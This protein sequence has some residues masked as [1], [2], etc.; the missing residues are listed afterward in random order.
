M[1][2]SKPNNQSSVFIPNRS[3]IQ[4][5]EEEKNKTPQQSSIS[6]FGADMDTGRMTKYAGDA[7]GNLVSQEVMPSSEQVFQQYGN[8]IQQGNQRRQKEAVEAQRKKMLSDA[9]LGSA[10][11][12]TKQNKGFMP[13]DVTE[14]LSAQLGMPIVGGN[15]TQNGDFVIYGRKQLQSPN[16]MVS[17]ERIEPIAVASPEMQYGLLKR[18]GLGQSMQQEIF[19]KLSTRFTEQQLKDRG[20][21]NPSALSQKDALALVDAQMKERKGMFDMRTSQINNLMAQRKALME[22]G[23][24]NNQKTIAAID[25][26]IGLL[27]QM[28]GAA[29]GV[30]EFARALGVTGLGGIGGGATDG[31]NPNGYESTSALE[32]SGGRVFNPE[33]TV[34]SNGKTVKRVQ[35]NPESGEYIVNTKHEQSDGSYSFKVSKDKAHLGEKWVTFVD[36]DGKVKQRLREENDGFTEQHEDGLYMKVKNKKGKTIDVFAPVGK[37]IKTEFGNK[38]VSGEKGNYTLVDTDEKPDWTVAEAIMR[39]WA[40]RD[41]EK[42]R[43]IKK[44]NESLYENAAKNKYKEEHPTMSAFAEMSASL[45]GSLPPLG[46]D[47][48]VGTAEGGKKKFGTKKRSRANRGSRG[49]TGG[50][51]SAQRLIDELVAEKIGVSVDEVRKG[52]EIVESKKPKKDLS[53]YEE[54][55]KKH[56]DELEVIRQKNVK[57]WKTRDSY[58]DQYQKTLKADRNKAKELAVNILLDQ[59]L[60]DEYRKQFEDQ[61]KKDFTLEEFAYEIQRRANKDKFDKKIKPILDK[62]PLDGR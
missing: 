10:L 58:R 21:T 22:E 32:S 35:H 40:N 30:S 17:G 11:V 1:K 27:N 56:A 34:E 9:H 52:R 7:Q 28:N 15:F 41:T 47:I 5:R 38:L 3:T 43:D 6:G 29:T 33:D 49:P 53:A 20:I 4:E 61:F 16:G 50:I 54:S 46:T 60:S 18:T 23:N 48:R 36:N 12:Y 57:S 13:T 44:S 19:D 24:P 37:V 55:L 31:N 42:P 14:A 8:L 39:N 2:A 59:D 25:Q 45:D 62:Y 26:Q 51:I